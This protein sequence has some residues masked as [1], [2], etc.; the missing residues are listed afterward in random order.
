MAIGLLSLKATASLDSLQLKPKC[1][2][3]SNAMLCSQ[4]DYFRYFRRVSLCF[5]KVKHDFLGNTEIRNAGLDTLTA[6]TSKMLMS[7]RRQNVKIF[8]F[9][10]SSALNRTS[11]RYYIIRQGLSYHF[12]LILENLLVTACVC[13]YF[14]NNVS[15]VVPLQRV[16]WVS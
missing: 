10:D 11:F 5:I 1:V 8:K 2:L 16:F 9:S 15:S 3:I 13:T 12:R 6:E 7:L 4:I 14:L